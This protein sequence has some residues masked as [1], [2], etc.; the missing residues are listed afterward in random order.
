VIEASHNMRKINR[1]WE[2]ERNENYKNNKQNKIK[3]ND[4]VKVRNFSRFKFDPY[5]VGPYKVIGINFNTVKLADPNT[6]LV[7]ERPV[8][9]KNVLKYNTTSE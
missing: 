1:K 6:N 3:I 9:L 7:L 5:Y 8:H 2:Q 4:L